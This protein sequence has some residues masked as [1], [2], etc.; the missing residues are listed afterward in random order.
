MSG[1]SAKIQ[2]LD[3]DNYETWRMQMEPVLVKN[4]LWQYVNGTLEKPKSSVAQ[5]NAATDWVKN[6]EN[7]KA[8]IIL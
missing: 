7:A 5:L 8:D 6:D 3:K 1:I 4:E 2:V